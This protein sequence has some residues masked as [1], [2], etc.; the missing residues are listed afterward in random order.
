MEGSMRKI[1]MVVVVLSLAGLGCGA[2]EEATRT[3]RAAAPNV[4]P[5]AA[6]LGATVDLAKATVQILA[7]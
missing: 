4:A 2:S 1:G 5:T 6:P 3:P 7:L